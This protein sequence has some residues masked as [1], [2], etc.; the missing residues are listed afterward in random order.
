MKEGSAM[1]KKADFGGCLTNFLTT[2]LSGTRNYS[3][4]TVHAYRDTFKLFLIYSYEKMGIPAEKIQ[5]RDI[6]PDVVRGFIDWLKSERGNSLRT[7]N[8]RLAAIHSFFRYL[9]YRM[10]EHLEQCQRILSVEMATVETP[11]V[12]YLTVEELGLIFEQ[13]SEATR[14]GRRDSVLLRLLYD[15]AARVQELCDMKVRD[16]YLDENPHVILHGKGKKDRYVPIVTEV[17]RDVGRYMSEN[18]LN[19]PEFVDMPLFTNRRREK[20]SRAG[21]AYIVKKYADAA[22]EKSPKIPKKV[23]PH[24]FRHTKATHLCQAGI[25]IIY[26][27]DILGHCHVTTTEIYMRLNVEHTRDALENAYPE[28]P[29]SGLP[30]WKEDNS[31]MKTLNSL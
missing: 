3:R 27:R 2:Y 19:R 25:D 13:V 6:T 28:L 20:L 24:M 14:E 21:V 30:D 23:T 7:A 9:Q 16:V 17:A 12:G 18:G 1:T 22:R 5:I 31:L 15:T 8:H 4:N 10:P 29:T 11:L 26:I